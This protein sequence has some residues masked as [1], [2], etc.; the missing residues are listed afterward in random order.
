MTGQLKGLLNFRQVIGVLG[1]AEVLG[2]IKD[3]RV[4]YLLLIRVAYHILH[5]YGSAGDE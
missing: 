3:L 2:V 5:V 4:R 1:G